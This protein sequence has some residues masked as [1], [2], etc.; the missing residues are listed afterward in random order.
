MNKIW[1]IDGFIFRH[2]FT[3]LIAGPTQSGKTYFVRNILKSL[4][5]MIDKKIN[6]I[7]YCYSAYQ[8]FFESLKTFN[9]EFV[10]GIPNLDDINAS[11][12]NLIILDD[13][14]KECQDNSIIQNLFTVDSHHKNLSV[15]LLSQNLFPQGKCSRP[16]SLNCHYIVVFN[17]PTNR[18]QIYSLARQMFPQKVFYSKHI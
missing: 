4:H 12:S 14:L 7:I 16:I 18:S 8:P 13:L 6:R 10:E 1:D 9:I 2:P 11:D 3:C 5:L 17:N 15:F